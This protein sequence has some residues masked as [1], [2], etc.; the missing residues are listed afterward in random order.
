MIR[1]CSISPP[2]KIKGAGDVQKCVIILCFISLFSMEE[3]SSGGSG[4]ILCMSRLV[5]SD[6]SALVAVYTRRIFVPS[7]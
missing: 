6:S 2:N 7:S 3:M 1:G 5:V 4:N